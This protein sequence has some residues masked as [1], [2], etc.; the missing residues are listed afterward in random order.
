MTL[1]ERLGF[2]RRDA[3]RFDFYKF[4]CRACGDC[5]TVAVPVR[6][7]TAPCP[8]CGQAHRLAANELVDKP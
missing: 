6:R 8:N 5:W 1:R 7:V 4:Q 2:T 3:P